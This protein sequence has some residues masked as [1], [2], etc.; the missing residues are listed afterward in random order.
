MKSKKDNWNRVLELASIRG[1][2][3]TDEEKQF[4]RT[5]Y[6]RKAFRIKY[7]IWNQK[8]TNGL[9]LSVFEERLTKRIRKTE[10]DNSV[11]VIASRIP[12]EIEYDEIISNFGCCSRLITAYHYETIEDVILE[13]KREYNINTPKE[14]IDECKKRGYTRTPDLFSEIRE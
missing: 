12:S 8:R 3:L 11:E 7:V 4:L 10:V 1:R 6:P 2:Q 9:Y 13:D 5:N 14:F